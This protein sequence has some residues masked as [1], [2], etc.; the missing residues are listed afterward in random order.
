MALLNKLKTQGSSYTDLDGKTP[1][2]PNFKDSKV[3]YEYSINDTPSLNNLPS[4]S[5]LDLQG[6]IPANNYRDNAPEGRTF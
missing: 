1:N 4:P 3:H 5:I 2:I 6:K